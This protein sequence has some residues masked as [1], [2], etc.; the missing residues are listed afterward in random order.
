ML[1]KGPLKKGDVRVAIDKRIE[2]A[3]RK[4]A[5][6]EAEPHLGPVSQLNGPVEIAEQSGRE[7]ALQDVRK[8]L[9]GERLPKTAKAS[10]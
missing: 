2:A 3:R 7:K 9:F 10:S 8:E 6:L 1:L 5:K 4:R